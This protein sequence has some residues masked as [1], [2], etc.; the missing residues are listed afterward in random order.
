M[1]VSPQYGAGQCEFNVEL[2]DFSMTIIGLHLSVFIR[3]ILK[4]PENVLDK[5][6]GTHSIK[7]QVPEKVGSRP[8]IVKHHCSGWL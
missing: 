5:W 6:E 2:L 4:E 7:L 1:W 8:A 3:R